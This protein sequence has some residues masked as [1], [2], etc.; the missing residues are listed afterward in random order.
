ML[1]IATSSSN[2][3]VPDTTK[4]EDTINVF[5]DPVKYKL[6]EAVAAFVVP[7]E[8][9]IRPVNGLFIEKLLPMPPKT[10][11]AVVANDAETAFRT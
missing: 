10:N 7:S 5:G 2:T 3:E 8:R 1:F 6:A 9:S 11:D 4:L